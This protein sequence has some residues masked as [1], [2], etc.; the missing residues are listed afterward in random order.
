MSQEGS[1]S[2][3]YVI[4]GEEI[5]TRSKGST[6]PPSSNSHQGEAPGI[7]GEERRQPKSNSDMQFR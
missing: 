5:L 7:K 1:D 3:L 4:Q 6:P 2:K